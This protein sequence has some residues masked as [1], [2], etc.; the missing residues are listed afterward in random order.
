MRAQFSI[1]CTTATPTPA[2]E[3]RVHIHIRSLISSGRNGWL[4]KSIKWFL[5]KGMEIF[6]KK[7]MYVHLCVWHM[8]ATDRYR[9]SFRK[10]CW[11]EYALTVLLCVLCVTLP[12]VCVDLT[13]YWN[14]YVLQ[15][16]KSKHRAHL[17]TRKTCRWFCC[18]QIMANMQ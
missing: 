1:T 5:S 12:K 8:A 15:M 2:R 18:N 17:K 6:P 4:E 11:L 10:V 16:N 9:S 7:Y 3:N 13:L 14:I